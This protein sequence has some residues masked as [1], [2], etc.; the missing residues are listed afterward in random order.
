MPAVVAVTIAECLHNR[1]P[2]SLLRFSRP[3]L[4]GLQF[5]YQPLTFISF[6]PTLA[7][8]RHLFA[9]QEDVVKVQGGFKKVYGGMMHHLPV[10]SALAVRVWLLLALGCSGR[11]PRL[12]S[13]EKLQHCLKARVFTADS[14][15]DLCRSQCVGHFKYLSPCKIKAF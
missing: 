3:L 8:P 5:S 13:K 12:S 7:P 10:L 1:M 9:I 15:R 6:P 4:L 14:E 2:F 11:R